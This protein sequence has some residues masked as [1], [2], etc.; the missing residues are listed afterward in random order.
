MLSI[1]R[2][3]VKTEKIAGIPDLGKKVGRISRLYPFHP[4][5]PSKSLHIIFSQP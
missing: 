2:Q 5:H 1:F 3:G 4:R